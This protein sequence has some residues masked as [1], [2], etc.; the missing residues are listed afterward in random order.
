M[1][2][3]AT[4]SALA[5]A[6]ALASYKIRRKI[7]RHGWELKR[8]RASRNTDRTEETSIPLE[9]SL[10]QSASSTYI[11]QHVPVIESKFI[12]L[13]DKI[14]KGAFGEVYTAEWMQSVDDDGA[15]KSD[16]YQRVA[17]KMLH[18]VQLDAEMDK[19]AALLAKLDHP[20]VLKLYGVCYWH[21]QV[22]LV[23]EL[24]NQGDL[25]SYLKNRMP[26]CDN[27]SQFP[28]AL[29]QTELVNICTQIC[30]G[31]CYIASQQIVHRDLA[32]RNCLVSGEIA[33]FSALAFASALAS[34]KIRRKIMRHG[35]ELKRRR[36]SRNT[37]RTEETSI[38]LE[39]SL[40]QSASSTYIMQHVPVIESKFIQLKDKI[41]KGAF[42]EVYTAE[43]MQSVDDDGA[44]KSDHYQRVAVKMLHN[45]QLDA[46]M[47]KEAALLAKLDHPN[48][49]KLY[50][51]C[52]WHT[53][54]TLVL[55]LM[56]QGDL[57]SYL[58]NRM[59]RCDNYSQFPPALLQ[60]EL[61]NICTQIS[62]FGM[63]RRLYSDT[64]Y[65]RM[66][67]KHTALPVRCLPPEC[68]CSG[69]FTHQSDMW[70]FGVTLFE[71]FTYGDVPFGNLSNNE[72]LTTVV[73]A[74]WLEIPPNW[75]LIRKV[76]M[77]VIFA[78]FVSVASSRARFFCLH[79]QGIGFNWIS[80]HLFSDSLDLDWRGYH[81]CQFR[82]D[83]ILDGLFYFTVCLLL[84]FV[85]YLQ[86]SY[87]IHDLQ[88]PSAFS[89]NYVKSPFLQTRINYCWST[90]PQVPKAPVYSYLFAVFFYV[91]PHAQ[92]AVYFV[93]TA[94]NWRRCPI[95]LQVN[96]PRWLP[97]VSKGVLSFLVFFARLFA[98]SLMK[99][100]GGDELEQRV[101]ALGFYFAIG[102]ILVALRDLR[103]EWNAKPAVTKKPRRQR[104]ASA[105]PPIRFYQRPRRG[106]SVTICNG[107][108]YIASQ[109]IVHR[110]LAARNCLVSGESDMKFCSA[111][112][113]PPFVVKI[114]DFGMSRRLY[115]DTEYYRMHDKHMALPVRCLPPECLSSGKFTHQ[116]DM[117]SFGVTLFEV[118][119][120]GDVPFGN[121]SN[122]EVLTTVVSGLRL[123]IPPNWVL[124]R[125]VPMVVIFAVFVSVASSRARFFCLHSQGIGFN[126][127]SNHLFSDSLDLDWR[128][129][130]FCQFRFDMI[131]DGLLY[132]TVC[133][134]LPFVSYLQI[135]YAIHDLQ[136]PSAFSL[137]YVKS[138]FLQTR[139]NYC[140]SVYLFA[141]FFYVL[142][143]AQQAVYFV[144]TA[145][146]WRRCP[147]R[148]QVNIPRWLPIVS[149]GVLSF[150][151]FFARLFAVSLMKELGGD[152]LEQRV[153][154]LGFYFAIGDIL[155]ALRDLR[156]ECNAKPAVTKKPRRQRSASARPPIRFYQRPRRGSRC[157]VKLSFCMCDSFSTCKMI[158]LKAYWIL[159]IKY[160]CHR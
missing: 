121:L 84:P 27:Y 130:H 12:Q 81:F 3:V 77:V 56:N 5:F 52:Y 104:S 108:C 64:E 96:I 107:M 155:V 152:E 83:M 153:L 13:K 17:V 24:M 49:L 54:V 85:T 92:Q 9:D 114:S 65:Y 30:N 39:D 102:D 6:S 128:G 109:Q 134:L 154:A 97:I 116:S 131:L 122:N 106:S 4:F 158:D 18:N 16:H 79:S 94:I 98:V 150:L 29:L 67:D 90:Q 63:S 1:L 46:E 139:I 7:M 89:L 126:W 69:N 61:V 119:T 138:P 113:R 32:A 37:D 145:I 14:G 91:L 50:G 38:P 133:L 156:V 129:Y 101:L 42:G 76:P 117:W 58:K 20:N 22:T 147:I 59:P 2:V 40:S 144:V 28:P 93:V 99:E 19:E 140:W 123:E 118:F 71:V 10:S 25:K 55:E 51:V 87:A 74:L 125:K 88:S 43:W 21:T 105:R 146:N 127:I 15:P 142:P 44:P 41:G 23:L 141:V 75:V 34:Y 80:N 11:M 136:S 8:R 78:V 73:S 72:V 45:V 82:F 149:K 143:H 160:D 148:L 111:A 115:S 151:V 66:H 60:T 33:T 86:I 110:D 62:G 103:V 70:S 132:F 47:D 53:Q 68:L 48:V 159:R 135:S 157:S 124:I 26:R 137:N 57:K 35:W 95:R 112:F 36:A 120:Y 31:L 100:L